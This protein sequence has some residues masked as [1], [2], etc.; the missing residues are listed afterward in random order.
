MASALRLGLSRPTA[1]TMLHPQPTHPLVALA[2]LNSSRAT[3][4]SRPAAAA[5]A[6]APRTTRLFG[7]TAALSGRGEPRDYT[8]QPIPGQHVPEYPYGSRR[9][10]K[11][12]NSG[13]Y[14]S[15]RIQ[16]GNNVTPKHHVRTPRRWRPNLQRKRLWSPALGCFVQTRI[17]N[18]VLRTVD[19]C[20]GL[21]EYLLGGKSARLRDLGPWGWKL[22]WRVMQ[23]DAVKE[24]F[25]DERV[26]LGLP[27][28]TEDEWEAI[29][30]GDILGEEEWAGESG[31]SDEELD[32]VLD[33]EQDI[34]LGKDDAPGDD[35]SPESEAAQDEGFMKEARP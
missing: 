8:G 12:S 29:L 1:A 35:P 5:A 16:F 11:Q 33:T 4:P 13:L 30:A 14:G 15:A 32:H 27:D 34:V 18:R 10:Y 28:W 6:A 23:T 3:R 9:L 24:R 7:T 21:D 19:K 31:V 22:R 25:R 2:A 26:R 20:G 17:T